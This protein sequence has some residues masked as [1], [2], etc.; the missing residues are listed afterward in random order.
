MRAKT[1]SAIQ[2]YLS[3]LSERIAIEIR[4]DAVTASELAVKTHRNVIWVR[5]YLNDEVNAG[6][7]RLV[8]K[9]IPRGRGT[10]LVDAYI[11]V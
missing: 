4:Q 11:R 9:R 10:M 5:K 7:S 1:K 2:D 6:R 3:E 8:K